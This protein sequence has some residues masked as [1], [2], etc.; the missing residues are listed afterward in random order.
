MPTQKNPLRKYLTPKKPDVKKQDK[1]DFVALAAEKLNCKPED[2][3]E[4]RLY[5]DR[6]IVITSDYRKIQFLLINLSPE[7][8]REYL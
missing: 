4:Y 5:E 2:L 7:M 8:Y 6:I 1:P 3:I